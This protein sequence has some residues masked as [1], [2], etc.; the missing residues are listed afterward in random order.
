[1]ELTT[2]LTVQTSNATIQ[3]YQPNGL[4]D[5]QANVQSIFLDLSILLFVQRI[6]KYVC[7]YYS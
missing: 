2:Q 1:M 5:K 3:P 6:R 7:L 4:G